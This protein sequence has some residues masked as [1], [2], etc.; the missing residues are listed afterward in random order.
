LARARAGSR[1][2]PPVL[3]AVVVALSACGSSVDDPESARC[4]TP[5]VAFGRKAVVADHVEIEVHFRCVGALLAGTLYLPKGTGPFPAVVYVH[6]SGETT[7]W[8]WHVPWV[9]TM[10]GAGIGFMSYDK[11]GVGESEGACCPGD[12]SHFNLLAADADG[13]VNALR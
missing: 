13:A 6:S 1:L 7:R 8:N 12:E 9:R 11:R 5:H 10:V 2:L 3:A 4:N